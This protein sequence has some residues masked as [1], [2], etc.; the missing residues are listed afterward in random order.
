MQIGYYTY[1]YVLHLIVWVNDMCDGIPMS[2]DETNVTDEII[3][4]LITCEKRIL[5]KR[6][7]KGHHKGM[8]TEVK[9]DARSTDGIHTFSIRIKQHIELP[10]RFSVILIYVN[11]NGT[12][13]V[14]FR[15]NGPH[16]GDNNHIP[17]HFMFHTHLL[18]ADE[19]INHGTSNPN[20]RDEAPYVTLLSGIG[21]FVERC[22]I[23]DPSSFLRGHGIS[24]LFGESETNE[25]EYAVR[26]IALSDI[27]AGDTYE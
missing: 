21:F 16:S 6:R 20:V 13:A 11:T 9:Y 2:V 1:Y 27:K 7:V 8:W 4:Y 5:N 17:E 26:Q 18:T 22:N 14:L 15:C 24:S 3:S 25:G 19:W 23:C 12:Q 10:N